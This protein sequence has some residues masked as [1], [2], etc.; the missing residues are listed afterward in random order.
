MN[1]ELRIIISA[2]IDKLKQELQKGQDELKDLEKQGKSSGSGL[3]KALGAAGKAVGVAMKAVGAAVIAAGA[4]V[5]GLAESTREYRTEQAKLTTAFETAGSSAEQA[6]ETYNDLYRV[7]GDSG[8]ATEAAAHLAKLTTNQEELAEWTR[9]CQGIYATFGDSLPIESLTEAANETAKTGEITGALADALNWAGVSEDEF[10]DQLF[11]A[12]SE[13]EREQIIRDT[14]NGLYGEAADSYETTAASILSANEA[15]ALLTD[16]LAEMGGAVEPIVA[17]FK[18]G[19]ATALQDLVPH[20][21]TVTEGFTD[22]INGVDGGAEKMA[23]GIQ[24]LIDSALGTITDALPMLLQTGI[25]II[26]ALL[27]GIANSL[28]IVVQTLSEIIPLILD[29]LGTLIPM[30]TQ[31]ILSSLPLVITT[32][33]QAI[34]QIL[35]VL[36]EMI[37]VILEQIVAI[38]PDI[39]Q[40]IVDNIP[41]LLN[42]AINFLM[43]IVNAIPVII[44]ALVEAL[45]TIIQSILDCLLENI[46]V[47]LDGALTLLFAIIDAIPILI[48]V[49][50]EAIPQIID[51]IISFLIDAI[52]MLLDG[53][54]KLF[55]AIVDA[56]PLIIP[57]LLVALLEIVVAVQSNMVNKLGDLFRGVWD[58]IVVVFQN[59]G[60]HFKNWFTN[61]FEGIKIAFSGIGNYFSGCWNNVKNAFA[62][63]G[64]WF[65]DIFKK[66]FTAIKNAFSGIGNFFTGIWNDIKAIFN[67]VGEVVGNAVKNTVAKAINAVLSTGVNIING[68]ISAINAAISLI[69]K[70][71]GVNINK[72]SKLEVPQMAK[73]GIVDEATLAVIGEQGKE[74]VVPLENNTE[75]IDMLAERLGGAMGGDDRPIYL[76]VD[77]TVFAKTSIKSINQLTKQTGKLDLVLA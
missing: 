13:A 7:L 63:V 20:F 5:V 53:A 23:S 19:L 43:A 49:L 56:L 4:A 2:E 39:I 76:M 8:Q 35:T 72:L 40:A 21:K 6:K 29:T 48:P 15:Q 73:G 17:I 69:N 30:L 60:A 51:A 52:P 59:V 26:T 45:P 3:A 22:V 61:A 33:L 31:S 44:P 66:A 25:Q 71:P 41:V 54:L 32:I 55:F 16:S 65:G 62:A 24:S 46:P 58:V 77:G 12:N 67:K 68:F 50:V 70:I 28:P 37:P 1:E 11:W 57:Q 74:A 47:L 18:Q 38:L 14:L 34:G 10:A 64:N 75:W 42:A 27:N 9:A 36:G